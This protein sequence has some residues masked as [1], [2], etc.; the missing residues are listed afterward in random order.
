M[1]AGVLGA[2]ACP[3]C[4]GGLAA[5]GGDTPGAAPD[6]VC[7]GCAI[8]FPAVGAVPCLVPEPALWRALWAQHLEEYLAVS[9]ARVAEINAERV[10]DGLSPRTRA[11]LIAMMGAIGAERETI[12]RLLSPVR[13]GLPVPPGLTPPAPAGRRDLA[14]LHGFETLFRDWAWGEDESARSLAIVQRLA[15]SGWGDGPGSTVA[16]FGAGAGRLAADVHRALSPVRTLAF[17]INPL[18]L[19][20]AA[21]VA[22]GGA[23]DLHEFP[24]GPREAASAVVERRLRCPF[25]VGEGLTFVLADALRAPLASGAVDV[26]ITPWFIDAVD[27][28]VRVT[29]AAV[30]RVL[31]PGGAWI[32]VGPLRFTGPASR[33][34]SIEEVLEIVAGSGFEL[35][36]EVREQVPYF[37]SPASGSHR[38]EVVY[39]FS[40]RRGPG[41]TP[42]ADAAPRPEPAWLAD[43]TR[44]VPASPQVA[45]LQRSAA[46][47]AGIL[48]LVDGRRSIADMAQIL[49]QSW[50]AEPRALEDQL[51]AF[52]LRLHGA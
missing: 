22:G 10:A 4:G 32:N 29:A 48:A 31:R 8:A 30:G 34:Y 27:A 26:V 19:L 45:I 42:A 28:D 1:S 35:G 11:R 17:D 51:R 21:E 6:A 5:S 50:G 18:P 3:R 44:P 9:A 49:G 40:A 7:R 52:L 20:V 46:F 14:V 23:V 12:E 15:A 38:L 25:P 47:T 16:I 36:P 39:G 43:T 13:Q 24:V 2:L 33:L 41:V 37:A